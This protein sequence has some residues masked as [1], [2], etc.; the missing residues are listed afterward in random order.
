MRLVR[1]AIP[2]VILIVIVL[3]GYRYIWPLF[4][5]AEV[6][7]DIQTQTITQGDLRKVVPADGLLQPSVLVEVKSKASGVV[8]LIGVEPGDYVEPGDIIVELDK[9]SLLARQRQAQASLMSAEAQLKKVR[10]DVSP[11]GVESSESSVRQAQ[12]SYDDAKLTF[13]RI[14]ELHGKGYATDDELDNARHS[15]SSAEENLNQAKLQLDLN[16]AGDDDDIAVAEANVAIRQ[17]E[18]DDVNEELAN[19][20]IR[21]PIAGKVLT[22]PVELG[23][24]VASGTSGNTSGTVVATIGDLSTLYVEAE[25]DETDLGSVYIG[26]PCRVSFDAFAD[27]VWIGRINKI[28][29]QGETGT[30]SGTQFPVDIELDLTPQREGGG[31]SSRRSGAGGGR[32]GGGGGPPREG[33]GG[34]PPDAAGEQPAEGEAGAEAPEPEPP[35]EELPE[36]RPN[37]TANVEFVLEDHSGVLIIQ[38]RMVQYDDEGQ[39][40]VEVLPDPEDQDKRERH[41]IELGFSNGM[42]Y[43]VVSGLEAGMTVI[44]EREIVED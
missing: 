8:E 25:L 23:T 17:A 15:L 24:A 14:K 5:P 27:Y 16:R 38:A 3:V 31:D 1:I 6:E 21:S 29:P 20:T 26:M 40:Y 35:A 13:D 33:G 34:P 12:L 39:A 9:E 30:G 41:D 11:E 36:L 43:E 37:M 7:T 2:W 18:L 19:T 22:R 10:R 32:R 4:L 44:V 42:R 28:Y